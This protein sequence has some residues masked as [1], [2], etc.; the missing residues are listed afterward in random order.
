MK[1]SACGDPACGE[2]EVRS[3]SEPLRDTRRQSGISIC[4]VRNKHFSDV[5]KTSSADKGLGFMKRYNDV[6]CRVLDPSRI[7][8]P[9]RMITS[10]GLLRG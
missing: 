7:R 5:F 2:R 1:Q 10:T 6:I 9:S 4:P 8:D 3:R